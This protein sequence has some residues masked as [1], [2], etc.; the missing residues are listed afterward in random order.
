MTNDEFRM[1]KEIRNPN[2]ET[3]RVL[4]GALGNSVLGFLPSLEIRHSGFVIHSSFVIRH[5]DL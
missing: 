4:C 3:P 2:S 5:S 1:T